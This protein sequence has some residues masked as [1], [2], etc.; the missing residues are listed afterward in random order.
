M[1]TWSIHDIPV[2]ILTISKQRIPIFRINVKFIGILH[3]RF[4]G[5][6]FRVWRR[7]CLRFDCKRQFVLGRWHFGTSYRTLC[8]GT[9]SRRVNQVQWAMLTSIGT[10]FRE[11]EIVMNKKESSK[12]NQEN[13][14]YKHRFRL[15][16]HFHSH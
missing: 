6:F 15:T 7:K 9:Q 5:F 12:R 14:L 3:Q 10:V 8:L 4:I 11:C 13:H 16:G 2:S 1:V